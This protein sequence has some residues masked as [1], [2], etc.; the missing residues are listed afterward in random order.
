MFNP[1]GSSS[2]SVNLETVRP[3]ATLIE[4][5]FRTFPEPQGNLSCAQREGVTP[6]GSGA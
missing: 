4:R 5:V 1:S 2:V 6:W 3:S